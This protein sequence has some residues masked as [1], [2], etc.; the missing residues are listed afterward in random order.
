MLRLL[1]II[2]NCFKTMINVSPNAIYQSMA[3]KKENK[4][5]LKRKLASTTENVFYGFS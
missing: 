3:D 2:Y 5:S 4:T 1:I